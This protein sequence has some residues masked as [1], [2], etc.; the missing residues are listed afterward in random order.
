MKLLSRITKFLAKKKVGKSHRDR[1]IPDLYGNSAWPKYHR[2]RTISIQST[3]QTCFIMQNMGNL[4]FE[5]L[6]LV[7]RNLVYGRFSISLISRKN[8]VSE[9]ILKKF[10]ILLCPS[11]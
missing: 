11:Q 5:R 6:D 8:L 1:C 10:R 2:D 7:K 3:E 4:V 9:G